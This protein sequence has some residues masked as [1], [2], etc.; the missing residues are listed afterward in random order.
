MKNETKKIKAKIKYANLAKNKKNKI[1][2]LLDDIL[3]E[4]I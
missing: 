1:K 2:S 4:E 3:E